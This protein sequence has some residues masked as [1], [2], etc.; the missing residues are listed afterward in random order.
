MTGRL[1]LQICFKALGFGTCKYTPNLARAVSDALEHAIRVNISSSIL[2][3]RPS[4]HSDLLV[5]WVLYSRGYCS[6]YCTPTET[7]FVDGI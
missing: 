3:L 5:S 2:E 7:S 1:S 6:W 4:I